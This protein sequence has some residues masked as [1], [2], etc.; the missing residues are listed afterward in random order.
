MGIKF[1]SIIFAILAIFVAKLS[2]ENLNNAHASEQVTNFS[3][4]R[5]Y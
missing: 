2:I 4:Q 3:S 5:T 1:G